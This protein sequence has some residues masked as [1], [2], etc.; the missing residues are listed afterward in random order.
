MK[1]SSEIRALLSQSKSELVRKYGIKQLGIF[2]SYGRGDQG[3]SSDIDILVEFSE[4]IGIEFVDLAN[5]LERILEGKVDL[6]SK[7]GIKPRYWKLVASEVI[8]V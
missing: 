8:Y 7:D 6:V 5:E 3:P 4:P 2:G 1:T